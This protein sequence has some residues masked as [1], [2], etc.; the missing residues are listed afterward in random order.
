M[1]RFV[2]FLTLL[3]FAGFQLLQAQ[4]VE[5]SGTITNSDDGTPVPG[6]SIIVK[7]TTIGTVTS[8]E[9]YSDRRQDI[10]RYCHGAGCFGSR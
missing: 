5:L 9:G 3:L 1:K 4:A 6:A 7:G 8:S 10:N 2:L